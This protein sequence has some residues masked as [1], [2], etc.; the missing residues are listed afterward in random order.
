[1]AIRVEKKFNLG[2]IKF[3]F[4][5][6]LNLFGQIVRKDHFQ[7]LENGQG[8][9]GSGMEAL[10]PATIKRKKSNK[11]LVDT[12]KM[13]NL[14]IKKA[15]KKNQVVEIHPGKKQTRNGVSNQA[16][17]YYHQTGAGHLPQREWFGISKKAEIDA[18]KMVEMRIEQELNR[19]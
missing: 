1:M 16:I 3:D 9:D 15:N 7:R 5:K 12:G 18:I 8:V 2:R 10:K 19:A 13:R 6:E 4:S 17:G 14:I 11:I